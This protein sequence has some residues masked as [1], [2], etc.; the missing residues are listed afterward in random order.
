MQRRRNTHKMQP[1]NV[2]S[3]TRERQKLGVV[4]T[5]FARCTVLG[6]IIDMLILRARVAN[7]LDIVREKFGAIPHSYMKRKEVDFQRLPEDEL[8]SR[9]F[10]THSASAFYWLVNNC[11]VF[12]EDAK[13]L[14]KVR[15]CGDLIEQQFFCV[16]ESVNPRSEL[17][18]MIV[19]IQA[20]LDPAYRFFWVWTRN[21]SRASIYVEELC[22][23]FGLNDSVSPHT[24][25]LARDWASTRCLMGVYVVTR[26]IS[27]VNQLLWWQEADADT[28]DD[29][30]VEEDL[31]SERQKR[32]RDSEESEDSLPK[33]S[34][35]Q[36]LV[37]AAIAV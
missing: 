6:G 16:G 27:P 31:P 7:K 34:K 37:E 9:I 10:H 15:T 28:V 12:V 24:K 4:T 21:D 17:L 32:K 11:F 3:R 29:S 8:R 19:Q 14:E 35:L 26:H 13:F 5:R 22:K 2:V 36:D 30:E 1:V 23:L 33:R 18:D 20:I 25:S